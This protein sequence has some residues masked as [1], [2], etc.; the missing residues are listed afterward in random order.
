VINELVSKIKTLRHTSDIPSSSNQMI[1]VNRQSEKRP[2]GKAKEE[3]SSK[4]PK[5][6]KQNLKQK[7]KKK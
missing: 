7:Q 1:V 2:K 5:V 3:Q 6:V 4:K